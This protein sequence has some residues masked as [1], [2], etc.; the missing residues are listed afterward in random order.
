MEA[1]LN[2]LKQ[3]GEAEAA[4]AAARVLEAAVL[5]QA[6]SVKPPDIPVTIAVAVSRTQEYVDTHF[7]NNANMEGE[8]KHSREQRCDLDNTHA[9]GPDISTAPACGHRPSS[10]PAWQPKLCLNT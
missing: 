7:H 5:D 1:A 9:T 3:E 8:S 4:L 6:E 10:P 2:A